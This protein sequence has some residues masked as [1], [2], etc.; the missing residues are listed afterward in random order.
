[1]SFDVLKKR[2]DNTLLSFCHENV[3]DL[4]NIPDVDFVNEK[5]RE[6]VLSVFKKT[7]G[8]VERQIQEVIA[9]K[10]VDP[11]NNIIHEMALPSKVDRSVLHNISKIPDYSNL[12]RVKPIDYIAIGIYSCLLLSI[13][14]I[15]CIH[16]IHKKI[17]NVGIDYICF[18][19]VLIII[20]TAFLQIHVHAGNEFITDK[21]IYV[22]SADLLGMGDLRIE[23]MP[24]TQPRDTLMWNFC[25]KEL[26]IVSSLETAENKI[27][28]FNF[29]L[30]NVIIPVE[31][32]I[33]INYKDYNRIVGNEGN[34]NKV[35]GLLS[36]TQIFP[37]IHTKEMS[38]EKKLLYFKDEL[39]KKE[40]YGNN[41][42]LNQ[43]IHNIFKFVKQELEEDILKIITGIKNVDERRA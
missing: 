4:P 29:E 26:K 20:M 12:L 30:K 16:F 11:W 1:M 40:K 5:L 10:H 42:I 13:I 39:I 14:P 7:M 32:E 24:K 8:M 43:V 33:R 31:I 3:H 35:L 18:A 27:N 25:W 36:A 2:D 22:H 37:T 23:E 28:D 19:F 9:I 6:H 41:K 17:P 38:Y 15:L 34:Q 21:Y